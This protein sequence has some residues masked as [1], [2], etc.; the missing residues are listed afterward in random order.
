[1]CLNVEAFKTK[2]LSSISV[3]IAYTFPW[4][5]EDTKI[6]INDLFKQN[7]N[8][9]DIYLHKEHIMH[10]AAFGIIQGSTL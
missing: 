1:M 3:F 4:S 9:S 10:S 6:Y 2:M 7:E 5:L 8:N